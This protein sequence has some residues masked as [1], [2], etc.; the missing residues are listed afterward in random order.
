MWSNLALVLQCLVAWLGASV[1]AS[2]LP[3][4]SWDLYL[5]TLHTVLFKHLEGAWAWSP[6]SALLDGL[7]GVAERAVLHTTFHAVFISVL[8]LRLGANAV[9]AKWVGCAYLFGAWFVL[10][11]GLYL[12]SVN[13]QVAETLTVAVAIAVA[14]ALTLHRSPKQVRHVRHGAAARLQA[15]RR[16]KCTRHALRAHAAAAELAPCVEVPNPH[17]SLHPN[18]WLRRPK[19]I[20][21]PNPKPNPKPKPNP[22]LTL[23]RTLAL[24][25]TRRAIGAPPRRP[26]SRRS[27][28]RRTRRRRRRRVCWLGLGSGS[29]SGSGSGLVP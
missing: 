7:L 1:G 26:S 28:R 6:A 19:P 2:Y 17:P 21:N 13:A 18:P 9:L 16:G 23:T 8:V 24:T 25:L 22:N 27:R 11:S 4:A 14:V 12:G 15:A 10:A 3:L 29:W 20:P 5:D